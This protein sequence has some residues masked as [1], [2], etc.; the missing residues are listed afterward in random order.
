MNPQEIKRISAMAL[1]PSFSGLTLSVYDRHLLRAF[2]M[3]YRELSRLV[4]DSD[5]SVQGELNVYITDK[6]HTSIMVYRTLLRMYKAFYVYYHI[7]KA[8]LTDEHL[9]WLAYS[10]VISVLMDY[11]DTFNVAELPPNSHIVGNEVK[12]RCKAFD[13]V[14]TYGLEVVMGNYKNY[15]LRALERVQS[16]A[17]SRL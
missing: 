16:K 8:G 1:D 3:T 2:K 13:D 9:Q 11:P 12:A 14:K 4:E 17:L 5:A 15:A 6:D 7:E 10:V